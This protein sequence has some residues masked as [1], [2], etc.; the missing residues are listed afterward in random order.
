MEAGGW[1][2]QILEGS[3]SPVGFLYR[4]YLR[5]LCLCLRLCL[6]LLYTCARGG[7]RNW[8][9]DGVGI[10]LNQ[11][12]LWPWSLQ[13][14]WTTKDVERSASKFSKKATLIQPSLQSNHRPATKFRSNWNVPLCVQQL[15]SKYLSN[16]ILVR[17]LAPDIIW[18][19][20]NHRSM[21]ISCNCGA[22][23]LI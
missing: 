4:L 20:L 11:A 2:S 9:L 1:V 6:Y 14:W 16:W 15:D 7:C 10:A 3:G 5:F 23:N 21:L 12:M 13:C 18:R 19:N 8:S 17:Q 22:R